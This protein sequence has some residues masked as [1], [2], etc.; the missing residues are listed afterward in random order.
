MT[1]LSPPPGESGGNVEKA[2]EFLLK[3]IDFR[4]AS[5][6]N[7]CVRCGLCAEACHFYLSDGETDSIPAVKVDKLARLF[8]RYHTFLGKNLP[9]LVGA[10]SINQEMLRDLVEAAFGRCTMCGRC[11]LN[12]S[13]GLDPAEVTGFARALLVATGLVPA[14]IVKNVENYLHTG[15]SMAIDTADMRETIE[16]LEEDLRQTLGDPG[17]SMSLDRKGARILYAI[18]SR[19]VK[20][21]PLS[22][23]AAGTIFHAAGEDWTLCSADFDLSNYAFFACDHKNA[24][25][26]SLKLVRQAEVLGAEELVMAEC[27]HGF[28]AMRW[29]AA[30][31]LGRPLPL[32][33][34]GFLELLVDYIKSGRIRLDPSRNQLRVTLHD[35][36]NMVRNGGLVEEPR[37]VLRHAVSDFVEM[38]PNREHNYCCG[39]G[40]GLLSA[41]EFKDKR[42]Q[43]GKIKADQI[44]ATGAKIVATPC[45]NCIDQLLEL[46]LHYKLGVEIKTIA[47]LTADALVLP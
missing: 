41:S 7:A 37:F 21:F 4:T 33:V 13:V 15:N 23:S 19:E 5:Y 27:G 3:Q 29:E 10:R 17:A 2:L 46:N 16:W 30:K 40:G 12:C 44:A 31:N 42:I 25:E 45:H 28:R 36:C 22:I 43:A 32:P 35:P 24:G 1:T 11:S 34:R 38:V 39:G 6:L 47:E 20:F 14:G 26:I 8:R 18:N 9:A